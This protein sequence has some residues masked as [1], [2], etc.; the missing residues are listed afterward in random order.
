MLICDQSLP[1]GCMVEAKYWR[2]TLGYRATEFL[3]VMATSFPPPTSIETQVFGGAIQALINLARVLSSISTCHSNYLCLLQTLMSARKGYL[4]SLRLLLDSTVVPLTLPLGVRSFAHYLDLQRQTTSRA[5]PSIFS[6]LGLVEESFRLQYIVLLPSF[7]SAFSPSLPSQRRPRCLSL[8]RRCTNS[9]LDIR[10]F[11]SR[12]K[13][14]IMYSFKALEKECGSG[15]GFLAA[16]RD[17]HSLRDPQKPRGHGAIGGC[18]GANQWTIAPS[19]QM[20]PAART[21]ERQLRTLPARHEA[22]VCVLLQN[23][24][25]EVP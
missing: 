17:S 5:F 19:P 3:T 18:P 10:S 13:H 11:G 25:A 22:A 7:P 15:T 24:L 12:F 23:G 6:S 4:S 21:Q 1:S 8:F 20:S 9:R 14:F 16:G 2:A